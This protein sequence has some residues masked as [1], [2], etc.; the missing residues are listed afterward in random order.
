MIFRRDL[1]IHDNSALL[2]ALEKSEQV[3]PC[4]IFDPR[5]ISTQNKYRSL[6]A[7]QFMIE[8]LLDLQDQLIHAHGHLFVYTGEPVTVLAD[9]IK[10]YNVNAVFVNTDYTPFSRGRDDQIKALCRNLGV[11][12]E[13]YHDLLLVD[14]ETHLTKTGTPYRIFTPFFNSARAHAVPQPD[15][16]ML[17]NFFRDKSVRDTVLPT[18]AEKLLS[19]NLD[20]R[21]GRKN[22]LRL[23]NSLKKFK[24]YEKTRDYPE[25]KTTELSAHNKFG[26]VSIREVY[27]AIREQLGSNHELIRA[28]YWRDFFTYIGYHYPHVFGHAYRSQFEH[29]P[30]NNNKELF[31][32]WCSGETGFP[33]V[34]AAMRQLN[35]TGFMHNRARMIAASFL[36]KDLQINWLWGERYFAQKLVDY[37]PAVN[38]GNWQWVASTGTDATPYFRIFNPWIQQKKYDPHCEYIKKWVPELRTF[39]HAQIHKWY[40]QAS[41]SSTYPAPI[42]DHQVQSAKTI[43]WYKHA[44][45]NKFT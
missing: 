16:R 21:A 30:W 44:L 4:F 1:R 35:Q 9:I 37:D 23:L 8:S 38:N 39:T 17:Y 11:I 28:L 26:T 42:V 40:K 27:W 7:L 36:V 34:D 3:L 2:A 41:D 6:P 12:F 14:P 29:L 15:Q 45:H 31:E 24:N 25:F 33:I 22:A 19:Q 18:Q 20:V 10:N 13:S 43:R 5:Q 32:K